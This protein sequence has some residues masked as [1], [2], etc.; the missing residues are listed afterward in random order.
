[1]RSRCRRMCGGY[2]LSLFKVIVFSIWNF[3]DYAELSFRFN[4]KTYQFDLKF[5]SILAPL[6]GGLFGYGMD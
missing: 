3:L 5:G 6:I 1:M 2:F 4:D